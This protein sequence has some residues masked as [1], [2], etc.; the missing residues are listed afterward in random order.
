MRILEVS[1][2]MPPH[3]GGIERTVE[4]L[5]DGLSA[6]GHDVRWLSVDVPKNNKPLR[7]PAWNILE[8]SLGVPFPFVSPTGLSTIWREVRWAEVVHVHDP[9]YLHCA[10]AATVARIQSKPVL[11]TQH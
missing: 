5:R 4:L 6:R 10:A 8:D 1:N 7:I 2:Y 9:L 11:L 3:M